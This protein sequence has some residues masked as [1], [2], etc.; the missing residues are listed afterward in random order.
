MNVEEYALYVLNNMQRASA[1]NALNIT[2]KFD[3]DYNFKE[4]VN[5]II[6]NLNNTKLKPEII[7]KIYAYS[8]D[9]IK[10]LD[11][12]FKYNKQILIDDYILNIWSAINEH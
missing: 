4:F 12:E 5:L 7:Y 6:K 10:K 2:K 8:Y 11:S 9:V 1:A 3:T